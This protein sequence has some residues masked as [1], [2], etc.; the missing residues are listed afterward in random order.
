MFP[1][2]ES[3]QAQK[4]ALEQGQLRPIDLVNHYYA[5]IHAKNAA[6]GALTHL[7]EVAARSAA[8]A[9]PGEKEGPVAGLC[10]VVKDMIDVSQA[11]CGGGLDYLKG[12][13]APA[14]AKL[15][16]RLRAAGALILALSASDTGGFGIRS[17]EVRHPFLPQHIVG[18]SSG[19]SAAAVAAGFAPV[20]LGTDSGGSVRIPAACCHVM[21]FKPSHGRISRD[22]VLPFAPSVDQV[23][24]LARSIADILLA[25]Q[26]ADP[27]FKAG[28]AEGKGPP[29]LGIA[30]NYIK[31]AAAEI[32]EGLQVAI[33]TLADAGL[34]VRQVDL[35]LP[36]E[37]AVIHDQIV[38]SEAAALHPA[39]RKRRAETL[40]SVV[41]K[42][43]AY[44]ETIGA[45]AYAA[46]C[47]RKKALFAQVQEAFKDVD[48]VVVPTLP[49]LTPRT[50][51]RYLWM[52]ENRFHLDDS[53]RRFTFLFNLTG[54]P[55]LSLPLPQPKREIAVSIQLVGALNQDAQLLRQAAFIQDLLASEGPSANR[56]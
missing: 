44:A 53:L 32:V 31:G 37:T 15:V 26:V 41:R 54:H 3:W 21:G 8:Q 46:A 39:F 11:R 47:E 19:G 20:A 36:S 38:A 25:I 7:L 30:P 18:G 4:K 49:A 52:G 14:D 6:L 23:G 33:Q 50:T 17:P 22:G 35:P 13:V 28:L 10:L 43:L 5:R 42:T 27:D 2:P 56:D 55:V 48:V 40:P 51:D 29:V 34:E 24:F 1:I 9:L 45:Q 16:A 12:R